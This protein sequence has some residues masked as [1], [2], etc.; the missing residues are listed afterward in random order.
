MLKAKRL[1]RA[2]FGIV[3]ISIAS[4]QTP[5]ALASVSSAELSAS[6]TIRHFAPDG[7]MIKYKS[8]VERLNTSVSTAGG[9]G[10][11]RADVEPGGYWLEAPDL[12]HRGLVISSMDCNETDVVINPFDGRISYNLFEGDHSECSI[13]FSDAVEKSEGQIESLMRSRTAQL[14]AHQADDSRRIAKLK[15]YASDPGRRGYVQF[16]GQKLARAAHYKL[17]ISDNTIRYR[18]L[19]RYSRR[20]DEEGMRYASQGREFWQEVL[21][22]NFRGDDLSE[23]SYSTFHSGVDFMVSEDIL[24]GFMLTFD[25]HNRAKSGEGAIYSSGWLAGPYVT[26]RIGEGLYVDAKYQ[27]GLTETSNAPYGTYWNEVSSVRQVAKFSLTGTEMFGDLKVSPSASFSWVRDEAFEQE[28]V[29]G[30]DM[31]EPLSHVASAKVGAHVS[32][33]LPI[34]RTKDIGVWL[35]MNSSVM[36][37]ITSRDDLDFTSRGNFYFGVNLPNNITIKAHVVG[38]GGDEIGTGM[39]ANYLLNF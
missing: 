9:T 3:V 23:W 37:P 24:T 13:Y 12:S 5:F 27:V 39:G 32:Y 17:H 7:T 22:T 38:V 6:I 26:S 8:S 16:R 25:R 11:I 36:A 21:I 2:I 15:S 31:S 29:F 14:I 30:N 20:H 35:R 28:D 1:S 19:P 34:S 33:D 4:I 18:S 10:E